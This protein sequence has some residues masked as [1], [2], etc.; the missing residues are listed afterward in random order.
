MANDGRG[1]LIRLTE[2]G[3][4]VLSLH[5]FSEADVAS[6]GRLAWQLR[7][8]NRIPAASRLGPPLAGMVPGQGY[9]VLA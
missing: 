4:A 7:G 5:E 2:Y 6:K 3:M 9:Q 1:I 8:R